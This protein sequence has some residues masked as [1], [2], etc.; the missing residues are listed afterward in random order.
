MQDND[1]PELTITEAVR[2]LGKALV[3]DPDIITVS[4][5]TID[6]VNKT[7]VQARKKG[8]TL[9]FTY[10]QPLVDAQRRARTSNP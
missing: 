7:S 9:I 4:A 8:R 3:A 2:E 10:Q 6:S 1:I 5:L